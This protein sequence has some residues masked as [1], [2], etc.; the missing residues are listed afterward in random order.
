MHTES[1]VVSP[2]GV[3]S[4]DERSP[5]DMAAIVSKPGQSSYHGSR[6]RSPRSEVRTDFRSEPRSEMSE[7][8]SDIRGDF[9]SEPRSE[10]RGDYRSEPRSEVRSEPRSEVD[11]GYPRSG[12]SSHGGMVSLGEQLERGPSAY[13]ASAPSMQGARENGGQVAIPTG[14]PNTKPTYQRPPLRRVYCSHCT[15]YP[16]GFRG[17][18]ELRRHTHARHAA[19]VRRWICRE[20][21]RRHPNQP[22]TTVPLNTCKSCMAQKSYGAYYNAAAHLRRAHFPPTLNGKSASDW[23]SMSVLKEWM[24]EV[25]VAPDSA[26]DNGKGKGKGRATVDGQMVDMDSDEEMEDSSVQDHRTETGSQMGESS[27]AGASGSKAGDPADEPAGGQK[28]PYPECGRVLRDLAAHMLTH[29]A[30]RPE[31][32]PVPSCVYHTKGFARKYDKNRHALTHYRGTLIC[33]LCPLKTDEAETIF[34]R[35]DNFKRHLATVHSVETGT[36]GQASEDGTPTGSTTA[37][38]ENAMSVVLA[39][40]VPD[41]KTLQGEGRCSIC[42]VYYPYAQEFY[43][44]LDECVLAAL[45]SP[46]ML[47]TVQPLVG[48]RPNYATMPPPPPRRASSPTGSHTSGRSYTTHSSRIHGSTTT[49]VPYGYRPYA[50]SRH[51]SSVSGRSYESNHYSSRRMMQSHSQIHAPRPRA[52][53]MP[54]PSTCGSFDSDLVD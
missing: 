9:R 37:T 11:Y 45:V 5:M 29:Q 36:G 15:D 44:H 54:P 3:A 51:G 25:C 43:E 20:P 31:K 24:Q 53:P 10:I 34:C 41:P 28:C 50:G 26:S 13:P 2:V 7:T 27:A 48:G 32:C 23:P 49:S 38:Q 42:N 52:V 8:R 47:A 39:R 19:M 4:P 18:H 16:E 30:E 14:P 46:E 12:T 40:P 22:W 35:A 21:P 17:E 6:P 1:G 33:P